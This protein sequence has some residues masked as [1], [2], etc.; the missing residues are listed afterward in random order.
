MKSNKIYIMIG[1]FNPPTIGHQ[2]IINESLK[3]LQDDEHLFLFLSKK[4]DDKKNPLNVHLR[5]LL[6]RGLYKNEKR[7]VIQQCTD[8]MKCIMDVLKEV[9]KLTDNIVFI[10]GSDR[11]EEYEILLNKYNNIEYNFKN[12]EIVVFGDRNNR[13][14]VE[15]MSATKARTFVLENDFKNFAECLPTEY[16]TK[17]KQYLFNIIKNKLNNI[18]EE[19]EDD[20]IKDMLNAMAQFSYSSDD[21]DEYTD[22]YIKLK[23]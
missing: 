21:P 6:I 4:V 2:F 9:N 1:R 10:T 19:N 13:D 7:L 5:G 18:K 20:E 3:M 22:D 11:K 17:L 8:Q 23:L 14:Y 16:S 15:S 12:I